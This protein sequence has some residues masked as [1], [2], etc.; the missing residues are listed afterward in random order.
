MKF[1]LREIKTLDAA[2]DTF[3]GKS[4]QNDLFVTRSFLEEWVNLDPTWHLLTLGVFDENNDLVGALPMIHRKLMGIRVY[5]MLNIFYAGTPI[6]AG[7]IPEYSPEQ[8]EIMSLLAK[9]MQAK[10][11]YIQ[12]EFHPTLKDARAFIDNGWHVTP[13]Y[14]L[15]WDLSDLNA[16]LKGMNRKQTYVRKAQTMFDFSIESGDAIIDDFLRLYSNT[17]ARF[18]WKP[19]ASWQEAFRRKAQWLEKHNLLR[20]YVCRTKE[21]LLVGIALYVLSRENRI[22]Y[23]WLIGYDQE[24]NSKEFPPA[25]HYFAAQNLAGEF[26]I[27]DFG[28]GAN[29]SLYAF[30][31]S[32][33]A[34][35]LPF[36]VL[37]TQGNTSW[38]KLFDFLRDIRQAF[39]KLFQR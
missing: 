27:I 7:H 19:P 15:A 38:V 11:P 26:D 3:V 23:F 18:E 34:N 9:G 24:L 1:E 13:Q 36:W 20:A 37:S 2:W 4:R 28:E 32:L 12:I 35:S 16:V 29:P 10:F 39:I 21:G 5:S 22:G 14:T 30:K 31:D 8:Y 25:I 6:L 17:M 33:G